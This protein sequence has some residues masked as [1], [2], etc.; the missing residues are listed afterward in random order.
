MEGYLFIFISQDIGPAGPRILDYRDLTAKYGLDL[1]AGSWLL[2]PYSGAA[3]HAMVC[4]LSKCLGEQWPFP[5]PGINDLEECQARTDIMDV[6]TRGPVRG[7]E[8]IYSKYTS[9]Y[10]PESVASLIKVPDS[11]F[12]D[13]ITIETL[14]KGYCTFSLNWRGN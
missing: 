6:T 13:R 1:V 4:R 8:E 5:L 14:L 12:L 7:K 9:V 11:Y 3:T 2:M 10:S